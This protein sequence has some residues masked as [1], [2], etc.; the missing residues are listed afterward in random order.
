M[1]N[2]A[3]IN[4]GLQIRIGNLDYRSLPVSFRASVSGIGGPS[5]GTI[6]ATTAGVDVGFSQLL[7]P[8]LCRI[9]NLDTANYIEW[10]IHDGVKF[11]PVGEVRPGECYVIRLAHLFGETDTAFGTGTVPSA[12]ALHI[13]ANGASCP[14]LVEA[15]E[16]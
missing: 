3:T 4:C 12:A 1:A 13:K 6:V 9:M 10:G 16:S 5:P 15:F 8:G 11:Y 2:E 7:N 14:V